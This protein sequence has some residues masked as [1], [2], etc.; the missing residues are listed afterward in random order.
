V[1]FVLALLAVFQFATHYPLIWGVP[2]DGPI[3]GAGSGT[4]INP[5]H[6]AGFLGMTVPLALAYTVMSRFSATIKV[7]LAYSAVSCWPA[8]WFPFHAAASWPRSS[9]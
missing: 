7:L 1:G 5:N 3:Y 4:F 8:S 6:L 2:K 9:R